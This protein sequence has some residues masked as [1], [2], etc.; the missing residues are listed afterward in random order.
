[1]DKK[2]KKRKGTPTQKTSI[3]KKRRLR[4]TGKIRNYGFIKLKLV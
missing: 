2:E 1:M 4:F 3:K